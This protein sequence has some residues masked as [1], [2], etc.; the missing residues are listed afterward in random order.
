[1]LVRLQHFFSPPVFP[2]EERTRKTALLNTVLV[3]ACVAIAFYVLTQVISADMSGLVVGGC[4]ALMV[5]VLWW[6]LRR[7]AVQL[8]S[9]LF[10]GVA[11]L[12]LTFFAYELAG[13][14]SSSYSL[15]ILAVVV[16]GV[17]LGGRAALIMAVLSV[18]TGWLLIQ[19]P[20]AD[21]FPR[22][23]FLTALDAWLGQSLVFC[24]AALLLGLSDRSLRR[25]LT[26][27]RESQ[28]TLQYR[29]QELEQER[30]AVQA[31]EERYRNF[32][33]QSVEGIWLLAFDQPIPI[34]L[35][36]LEQVQLI[37]HTGY[38][39]ECNAAF[40][41]IYGYERQAL[42]GM[43]L[44]ELYGGQAS[45]ASMATTLKLVQSG[46]RGEN[47]ETVATSRNGETLYFVNNSVGTVCDGR[48][49]AIW[50]M[51]RDVTDRKMIEQMLAR[52]ARHLQ[53]VADVSRAVAS[54][55][56]LAELLPRVVELLKEGFDLYYA[57][58]FLIDES[59]RRT[60]LRAATGEAGQQQLRLGHQLA[61]D[62]QSMI[63]WCILHQQARLALDVSE[64]PVHSGN[65]LLPATRSEIALPLINWGRAIGA[66]TIQSDRPRA[67]TQD[68]AAVLQ[69]MA[70]QVAIAINNAQLFEDEKRNTALMTTLRDIG[71]DFS[72]QLELSALLEAIVKRAAQLLESP[73]GELLLVE[74]DGK[75]LHEAARFHAPPNPSVIQLGEGIS[76][77]VAQTGEPLI[78]D[79]YA[80]W[81]GRLSMPDV[82]YHSVVSVPM[83]WQS[84]VMGVLNVL[85]DR[86]AHFGP[87]D[88]T[89]LELFAAQA[90]VALENASLF[91]TIRRRLDELSVLHAVSMA[92]TEAIDIEQL[93]DRGMEVIGQ[94]L[95]PDY[96]GVVLKDEESDLLRGRLYRAGVHVPLDNDT[97][98]LGQGVV[99][100]VAQTGRSRLIP[101]VREEPTYT[102][103]APEILSELCVPMKIGDR[104]I[105][106][107]DVESNRLQAFS[108]A[109]EQ[110]LGTVAGQLATAIER[111]RTAQ[112]REALIEELGAKNSE[113]ERF[114]YTV[115]H[116]LKS[117]LITIRG[118]MGFLE[119]DA[120]DGNLDRL[121]SDLARITQATDK[122]QRLLNELLE[123]SRIGRLV[124]AP[125]RVP[126]ASIVREAV[127]LV[128]GRLSARGMQVELAP[129]LPEVF[130]D[131]TR[132]VEVLQNLI[133]NA[134]KFMS[135]QVEPRITIGARDEQGRPVFFVRDNGPG[136]DPR[137]HDKVFGLFDKLDPRSEG[138]GIG[139]A[140]VKRVIEMHGGRV[141]V[142]SA[143][144]GHGAT[145]C[146]TL[147]APA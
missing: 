25:A 21:F 105:G 24:V 66:L 102:A 28:A 147:P 14:G 58:L 19:T 123:L 50:G 136:I 109:D 118:F 45:A 69:T 120:A 33:E 15:L 12:G 11:F 37:H 38:V 23:K 104:I 30:S 39:A 65:P 63:G 101:D 117:P 56:D 35:P 137:Y 132:L 90:A 142:E 95:F 140:L 3:A 73:M 111:L 103:L 4:F 81:P 82:N 67:F 144:L 44:L 61:L 115:S 40:A 31:S 36:L 116:D 70:D 53:T 76:G 122:M 2:D 125:E 83:L 85:H 52:R 98:R 119:K 34:D 8:V 126:F 55:L 29:T 113:L 7:G 121:R 89:V 57:G 74:P 18:G 68:D 78:V 135:D 145:F 64:D 1:M 72:A 146:F 106:V 75:M 77:R 51:Q 96:A 47:R 112:D 127:S 79:D 130:A 108:T 71:L 131:R 41:R 84:R 110:L 93:L 124:N 107:I 6:G 17:L 143:G 10:S 5:G 129:D 60:V 114:T 49:T 100:A 134:A 48:L 97:V 27:A 62:D 54:I 99:G 91:D 59:G 43:R 94:V 138:T 13:P 86:P 139:L 26:A 42:Q 20:A 128:E 9:I 46:Y 22:L 80:L 87:D 32:I 133:D 16:A 92:A 141:W 88:V